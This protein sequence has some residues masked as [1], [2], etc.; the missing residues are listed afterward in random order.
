PFKQ[1]LA[2]RT[3]FAAA[4]FAAP[5]AI[6]YLWNIRYVGWLVAHI[7]HSLQELGL[8]LGKETFYRLSQQDLDA[9][10]YHLPQ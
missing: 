6:Y 2:R 10:D 7:G 1:G 8:T 9:I 4:C 5:M 3:G